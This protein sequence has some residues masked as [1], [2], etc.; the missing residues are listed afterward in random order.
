MQHAAMGDMAERVDVGA[1]MR[2][3]DDQIV[4]PDEPSGRTASPWRRGTT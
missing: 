1:D 3:R 4:C 2:P